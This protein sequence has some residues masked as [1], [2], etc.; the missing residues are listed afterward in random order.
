M[1]KSDV[2]NELAAAV[3]Q[4]LPASYDAFLDGLPLRPTLGDGYSPILDFGGRQGRPYNRPRLAESAPCGKRETPVPYAHQTAKLAAELRAGDVE[5]EGALS[6][7]LDEKGF[8]ID[9][10]ARGFSVGDD[11]N[12]APLF[13]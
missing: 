7:E 6:A 11:G 12:G 8:S 10:L 4:S 3:G 2:A 1:A 13:V 5:H 9:R